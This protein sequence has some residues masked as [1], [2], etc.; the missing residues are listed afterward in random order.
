MS[1]NIQFSPS[2]SILELGGGE[3]GLKKRYPSM[4]VTNVDI[5][6][7]NGVDVVR[8]LEEDFSDLGQYDGVY[9][10]YVAEHISWRRIGVFFRSCFNCLKAGGNLILIIPDTK[11]QMELVLSQKE[12]TFGASQMLFGDQNYGDNSHKVAFSPELLHKILRTIGFHQINI[13]R[14]PDPNARDLIVIAT[15]GI[16][17]SQDRGFD[18]S[19]FD[20]GAYMG[21]RDFPVHHVTV[22][23]ILK[24]KPESV[25][26]FGGGRGYI[27]K[28]LRVF[29]VPCESYDIST[30]CYMTRAYD[31]AS[32]VDVIAD[33]IPNKG[34]DLSFST[35]FLE[36]I[37][38]KDVPTVI[39]KIVKSSK[40]GL[41]G[42]N[43]DLSP[44]DIDVTHLLGTM[45][46]LS[47]WMEKFKEAD[48]NYT[49]EIYNSND[50][51]KGKAIPVTNDNKVKLNI[52]SFTE[53]FH[54][55][56]ENWDILDLEQ[57]AKANDYKFRRV[58]I[59]KPLLLQDSSVDCMVLH[60]VIEHLTRDEAEAFA[61]EAFRTLKP[62]GVIRV[63][64]PD[65]IKLAKS[66]IDGS[67][68]RNFAPINGSVTGARDNADAYWNL[69]TS[70]HKTYHDE[71]T[72]KQMFINAGFKNVYV[73]EFDKSKSDSIRL[74]TIDA[75]PEISV[76]VEAVKDA[77]VLSD[78]SDLK[79][80][81]EG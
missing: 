12:F 17:T 23:E 75:Q 11:A 56:W 28:H 72:L 77:P 44:T 63:S 66:Y 47:W 34:I 36:H 37:P 27:G 40:R 49:V 53:M 65:S 6:A 68:I 61:R 42:V 79:K 70:N 52:G 41:H 22:Q 2:D 62:G 74:E 15:K 13:Q 48:P 8:N 67:L 7:A 59:T 38:E 78:G 24:R 81:L 54:Y 71:Y 32:R 45:K 29:G 3:T 58:D 50:L 33:S 1:I 9:A 14:H 18:H 20:G 46:P 19:Y 10:Q 57:F 35:N 43:P 80:Y 55:S 60:H 51:E 64:T 16:V 26:E 69:A 39:A 5:R 73:S 4:K 21:Y 31:G 25:V 76:Y 30:H